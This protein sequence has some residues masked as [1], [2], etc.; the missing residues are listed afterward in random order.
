MVVA[1]VIV[2]VLAAGLLAF[3]LQ[4]GIEDMVRFALQCGLCFALYRGQ[5]WA[6]WVLGAL[7]AA[8]A[9]VLSVYVGNTEP[10]AMHMPALIYALL[11]IDAVGAIIL[12]NPKLLTRYFAGK[13]G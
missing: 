5:R 13:P 8:G 1:G 6:R 7:L 3:A 9:L 12:L 2:A 4:R 10:V 11:V